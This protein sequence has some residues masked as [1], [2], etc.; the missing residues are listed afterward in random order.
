MRLQPTAAPPPECSF[1]CLRSTSIE[2]RSRALFRPRNA[3]SVTGR[4]TVQD[5]NGAPIPGA[6]IVGTWT[7]PDGSSHDDNVWTN[8]NGVA[9]FATQGSQGTYTLKI[10]NIVRS[11]Y[12]FDPSHSVLLKSITTTR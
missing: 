10:V 3:R 8:A 6:L 2:L 7:L 4:V 11:L 9:V 1:H 12:T 5:E